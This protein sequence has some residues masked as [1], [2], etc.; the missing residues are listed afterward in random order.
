MK[1]QEEKI[2]NYLTLSNNAKIS[3]CT[4]QSNICPCTNI[5]TENNKVI[6]NI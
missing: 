4:S 3:F 5:L 1:S 6:I 2:I